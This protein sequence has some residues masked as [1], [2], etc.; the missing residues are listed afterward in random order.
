MPTKDLANLKSMPM[1]QK[2]NSLEMTP[3]AFVTDVKMLGVT[4][5]LWVVSKVSHLSFPESK[6]VA[7]WM[8]SL[9]AL[10]TIFSVVHTK[11]FSKKSKK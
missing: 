5:V 7:N 6:D 8:V 11:L 2:F 10:A 1:H 9:S 3:A 4:L